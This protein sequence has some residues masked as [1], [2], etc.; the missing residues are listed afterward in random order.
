MMLLSNA[1]RFVLFFVLSLSAN[2][3]NIRGAQRELSAAKEPTVNLLSAGDYTI[4]TKSG[5]STV[6]DSVITGNIAVSPIAAE[7]MTGFSLALDS[8]GKF[9]TS[10]QIAATPEAAGD[11]GSDGKAYA[12]N[13]APPTPAILSSAVSA[14]EAAY[15]DAA[16]RVNPNAAR[17]NLGSGV[18]GGVFGGTDAKLTPGVYT[19]GS[20]V[21]INSSLFFEGTGTGTG[22]GETDIFIIQ[23]SGNLMQVANTSVVLSN[24]ALATNI[25]W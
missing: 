2:A 1:C 15:T 25:F 23:M 14:M 5:I 19:F 10:T 7:A 8:S 6:P 4:L 17:I 13:Y 22:Q 3:E 16:G 24:G 12:A 20:D 11:N 21:T 9:S 18:L